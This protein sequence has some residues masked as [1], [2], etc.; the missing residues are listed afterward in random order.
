MKVIDF[1]KKRK[2]KFESTDFTD[3]NICALKSF[4]ANKQ[5]FM[6]LTDLAIDYLC[7]K[8]LK[9]DVND[10]Q[11]LDKLYANEIYKHIEKAQSLFLM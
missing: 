8:V 3:C 7:F 10:S 1:D 6:S 2:A 9:L 4:D 11:F 5:S